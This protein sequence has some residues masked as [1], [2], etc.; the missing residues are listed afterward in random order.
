MV[1]AVVGANWG[2]EEKENH[3]YAREGG[4]YYRALSGRGK[5]RTYHCQQ[6]RKVCASYLAVRSILRAY[7]KRDSEMAWR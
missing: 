2:D 1:K 6:L 7:N 4:G 3:R 5:C